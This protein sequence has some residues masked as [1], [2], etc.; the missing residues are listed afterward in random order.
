MCQGYNHWVV[1]KCDMKV[2]AT[3]RPTYEGVIDPVPTDVPSDPMEM[4]ILQSDVNITSSGSLPLADYIHMMRKGPIKLI[5]NVH[6]GGQTTLKV[7]YTPKTIGTRR[8]IEYEQLHGDASHSPTENHYWAI[9]LRNLT[10][11]A[12]CQNLVFNIDMNYWVTFFEPKA[13]EPL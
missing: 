12:W 7:N 6:A 4:G 2:T 10:G 13:Y 8:P 3:L 5:K 1:R 9:W 11:S